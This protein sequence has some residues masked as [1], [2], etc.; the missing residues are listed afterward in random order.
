MNRPDDFSRGSMWGKTP[1]ELASIYDRQRPA[2]AT[3]SE[4]GPNPFAAILVSFAVAALLIIG[5][6]IGKFW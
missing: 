6:L 3:H 2:Q 4:F 1:A 5:Y